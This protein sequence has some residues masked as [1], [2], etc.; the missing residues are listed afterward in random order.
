MGWGTHEKKL[1]QDLKFL[2]IIESEFY[3]FARSP[4]AAVGI[5]QFIP[6]TGRRFG[7]QIDEWVDERLDPVKA[8][9]AAADYLGTLYGMFGDWSLALASYNCGENRVASAIDNADIKDFWHLSLPSETTDYVPKFFAA[10]M[11]AKQP[12]LYGFFI[13][14]NPALQIVQVRL[15]GVAS[16]RHIADLVGMD[17]DELRSFNPELLGAHTPPTQPNYMLNISQARL[18]GF[19]QTLADYAP[20]DLYLAPP[21]IEKLKA[22]VDG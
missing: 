12:E 17:F 9:N 5:W 18:E 7:L 19:Q 6:G 14:P 11:I 16:L 3:P 4:A 10:M 20:E 8:S 2:P 22:P 15:E 21:D 1:P 13:E